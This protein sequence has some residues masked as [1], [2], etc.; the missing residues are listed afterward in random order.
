M[1][2]GYY[3]GNGNGVSGN[4]VMPMQSNSYQ[5]GGYGGQ[6]VM[7]QI[8][9]QTALPNVTM[10]GM[11]IWVD[12]ENSARAW[13]FPQGWPV[14]VPVVL[15]DINGGVFYTKAMNNMGIPLPLQRAHFFMDEIQQPALTAG[16]SSSQAPANMV[17]ANA[18]YATK[19]D[20]KNMEDRIMAA[21][22]GHMGHSETAA[23]SQPQQQQQKGGVNR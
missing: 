3:N 21:F 2:Y 1:A 6:P 23:M 7:P 22:N 13:Q 15:W 8:P 5:N 11:P 9:Y 18:D 12:G 10:P 20:M 19:D 4:T 17:P 14:N 16:Q